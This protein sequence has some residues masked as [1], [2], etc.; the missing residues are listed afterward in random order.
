MTYHGFNYS[1]ITKFILA[2]SYPNLPIISVGSGAGTLEKYLQSVITNRIICVDPDPQSFQ[3]EPI[4]WTKGIKPSYPTINDLLKVEPNVKNNS[5]MLL[6]W[7]SPNSSNYDCEAINLVKPVGVILIYEL[8]GAAGG[9]KLHCM[10]K[11]FDQLAAISS[12]NLV[13]LTYHDIDIGCSSCSQQS[14]DFLYRPLALTKIYNFKDI[15]QIPSICCLLWLAAKG[16]RVN[17]ELKTELVDLTKGSYSLN[18]DLQLLSNH[19]QC[20]KALMLVYGL[21]K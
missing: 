21:I 3:T 16:S 9:T 10:L 14:L 13:G 20:M 8:I 1:L 18:K 2:A 15:G 12:Q 17:S 11:R 19:K 7:P 5:L 4:D 6:A